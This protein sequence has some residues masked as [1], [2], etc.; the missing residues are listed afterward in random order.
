VE[1]KTSVGRFF[2][3]LKNRHFRFF[4]TTLEELTGFMKEPEKNSDS[5]V[6]SLTVR[7]RTIVKYQAWFLDF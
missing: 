3:F 7:F 2:E 6:G 5:L 4:Q 1:R